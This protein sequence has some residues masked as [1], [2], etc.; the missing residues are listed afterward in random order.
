MT[1]K[2]KEATQEKPATGNKE[3]QTDEKSKTPE[4]PPTPT[5]HFPVEKKDSNGSTRFCEY[6]GENLK[7]CRL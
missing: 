5:N 2:F 7:N 1:K 6:F 3:T 4:P